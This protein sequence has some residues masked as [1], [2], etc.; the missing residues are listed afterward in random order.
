M[1]KD[2]PRLLAVRRDVPVGDR[3]VSRMVAWVL[4]ATDGSA[5]VVQERVGQRPLVGLWPS[6][7]EVCEGFG[8]YL[9]AAPATREGGVVGVGDDV[10]VGAADPASV[11]APCGV[12]RSEQVAGECV[13]ELD[14]GER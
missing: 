9:V 12:L 2:V 10:D 7:G 13:V 5:V 8:G 6:L 4:P 3:W 11:L 14:R 1:R